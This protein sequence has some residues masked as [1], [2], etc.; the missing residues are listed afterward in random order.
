LRAVYSGW[1]DVHG[2]FGVGMV[3]T[4][5]VVIPFAFQ[6]SF[7]EVGDVRLLLVPFVVGSS[8]TLHLRLLTDEVVVVG[9]NTVSL[10]DNGDHAASLWVVNIVNVN[11]ILNEWHDVL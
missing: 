2:T 10:V 5:E 3:V 1:L 9:G 7:V 11:F 6:T 8:Y 4:G